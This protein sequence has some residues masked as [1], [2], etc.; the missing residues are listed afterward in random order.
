MRNVYTICPFCGTGCGLYLKVENNQ[1][2]GVIPSTKNPINEGK[3]CIKGWKSFQYLHHPERLKN[4]M[5]RKNGRLEEVSWEEALTFVA[6]KLKEIKEKY[7][8]DSI[9]VFSSAKCTNEENYLIQKFARVVIGTNNV[10]HCARLCHAST[11]AGLLRAFG[12]GAM[13]NSIEDIYKTDLI[14]V[15]GSNTTEQHPIIGA[16]IIN[17]VT[18]HGK[19]LIVADPRNIQLA[20]FAD[21]VLHHL[22]G[23]DV[24]L[25]NA[26]ANVIIKEKLYDEEF[27]KSRTEGFDVL[28]KSIEK[29]TPEYAE[30]ITGVPAE[31]IRAAARLYA[32]ADRA[33][34]FF[35]MGVTQH[36]QG[37]E[38]VLAIA[39]LAMLTGNVGKPGTG[40]N[41]L[42]GQNNVQGAGDMGALPNLLP[43]YIPIT[44]AERKRI[45]EEKWGVKISDKSGYTITE[46]FDAIDLGKVKAM[47]IVGENPVISDPDVN[48]VIEQLKALELLVVQDIFMTETA[49]LADVVLPAAAW[50]E[51]EGTYTNTERRVQISYKAVDPPGNAK[52]DWEIITELAKRLGHSEFNYKSPKDILT[53]INELVEIYRGITWERLK[54]GIGIQWPCR[55]PEDPGTPILHV[56]KFA[57]GK[58]KFHVVEWKQP[59]DWRNE[60]YPYLLTTG[61]VYYQW[62]TGSLTRRIPVLEREAPHPIIEMNPDDAKEIGVRENWKVT[63]E[64]RYG[65]V[66]AY[67][68]YNSGLPRKVVFMPFHYK[69][70]PANKLVGKHLDPIAKIPEYKV[71]AV[72]VYVEG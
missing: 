42:R 6:Q 22:P 25:F 70:A 20:K 57:R 50:G 47:Y 43:G 45:F 24:A 18:Q 32:K 72:K 39:N 29:C 66:W 15:T 33:M 44:D 40:V 41:P 7:G 16:K 17:A 52:P 51:K 13:T 34:I 30:K 35:A 5:I 9:M 64:S 10:D 8:P 28:A 37:T 38:N 12:S 59:P 23:T 3:L 67:V 61:R 65:K 11:V 1:A 58:G 36:V 63:V 69:E 55:S 2:I 71:T 14:F 19:M 49:E 4:P 60:E 31:K 62:H 26:M 21:L 54:D 56:G 46:A 53:E 27:I 48:H 68:K